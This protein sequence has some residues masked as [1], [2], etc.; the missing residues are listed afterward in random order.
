MGFQADLQ[1]QARIP[2]YDK[3]SAPFQMQSAT[4]CGG[5]K[6]KMAPKGKGMALLE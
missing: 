5:L 4:S 2:S 6:K 1:Y 3:A